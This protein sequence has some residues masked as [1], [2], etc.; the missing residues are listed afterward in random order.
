VD[1][2]SVADLSA[3]V[4]L[5]FPDAGGALLCRAWT[6]EDTVLEREAS[7]RAPHSAWVR[8]GWLETTPGR[9]IDLR[10]LVLALW[11]LSSRFEVKAVGL[12]RWRVAEL[13]RLLDEQGVAVP[14]IEVGQGFK[15][16]APCVDS[17]E[18]AILERRIRHCS[19]PL[20]WCVSNTKIELDPAGNRKPSKQKSTARIDLAA[21]AI[22]AVGL[23]ARTPASREYDFSGP[24]VLT[25]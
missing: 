23:Q 21:G 19:P 12:D 20:T 25:A 1:T 17:F 3:L 7:D 18:R 14:L 16:L 13:R 11:G 6:P 15:D 5:Y 22:M 2:S 9:S 8:A 24:M 10:A 4:G